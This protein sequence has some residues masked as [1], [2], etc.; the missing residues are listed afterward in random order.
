MRSH[1]ATITPSVKAEID[2]FDDFMSNL[3]SVAMNIL[4]SLSSA[5]GLR[6]ESRFEACH[7]PGVESRTTLALFRYPKQ[8][9]ADEGIG[10]NKHTD[11]GTL[12]VLLSEQWG[13]QVLSPESNEWQFVEPKP[14]RAVVNV[15]DSL[16][17]LAGNALRSCV[18]RVVPLREIQEED[19]YSIAYFLRP[20][21]GVE[22]M[23]SSGEVVTARAWHDRKFDVFR[24]SYE[25]QS[26]DSI[27][28]GGMERGDVLVV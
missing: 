27:L 3:E 9:S 18:H 2:L 26:R 16:R 22:Y 10:H 21:D 12:T 4:S 23:T 7:R 15:G 11:I 13:L 14:G 6:G 24:E 19:R 5:M 8:D 28:T 17:F 1:A 20:D 25:Q